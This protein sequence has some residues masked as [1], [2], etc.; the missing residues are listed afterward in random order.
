[1]EIR[2]NSESQ[3]KDP[4]QDPEL[5]PL[6][7]EAQR[8][9]ENSLLL[10]N[11]AFKRAYPDLVGL[12]IPQV[13]RSDAYIMDVPEQRAFKK[14]AGKLTVHPE[15]HRLEEA[16]KSTN[17][18]K[19]KSRNFTYVDLAKK[20]I[21]LQP[22]SDVPSIAASSVLSEL[23]FAHILAHERLHQLPKDRIVPSFPGEPLFDLGVS[24]D[25]GYIHDIHPKKRSQ[26]L[27]N[28][29]ME[30][31]NFFVEENPE[32]VVHGAS[33]SIWADHEE[34]KK[35]V[36]TAGSQLDEEIV[37]FLELP[38]LTALNEIAVEVGYPDISN[39]LDSSSVPELLLARSV[40]YKLGLV[41][42]HSTMKAYLAGEILSLYASSISPIAY[43]P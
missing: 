3:R 29:Y 1:M 36:T 32:A 21:I 19:S 38:L 31:I 43:L 11:A 34:D 41:D 42:Y 27:W 9:P 13:T 12:L 7:T 15:R 30:Y 2:S 40:L 28:R 37:Q 35:I 4:F 14:R 33:I 8:V 10:V 18:A 23:Y 24:S 20:P 39:N 17:R 5:A 22:I 25:L 6:L 26:K 16:L